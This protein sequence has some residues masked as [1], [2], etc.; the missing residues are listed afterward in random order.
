MG[1][2]G[3][4]EM[5]DTIPVEQITTFS[6][7]V[8]SDAGADDATARDA[9]SAMLHASLHGIDSHGFRLL[10]HY[11]MA[12]LGGRLNGAPVLSF[13]RTKAGTG[14]LDAGHAHGASHVLRGRARRHSGARAGIGAVGVRNS[15]HFG[16]AGA[17]AMALATQGLGGIVFGNSDSLVRLHD[18]ATRFHGTNPIAVG[19]PADGNPWLLDMATSSI[20]WNRV[21]LYGSL[22]ERLPEGI[23]SDESGMDVTDPRKAAMLA[24]LG[25]M[26]GFKGAALGGVAEIFSAVMT[27]M[28]ISPDLMS[29]DDPD[30]STRASSGPLLSRWTLGLCRAGPSFSAGMTHYLNLLRESPVRDGAVMAPGDRNGTK[31][32]AG[33]RTAFRSIRRPGVRSARLPAAP[34]SPCKPVTACRKKTTAWGGGFGSIKASF[35]QWSNLII[36]EHPE[37]ETHAHD[38]I[39]RFSTGNAFFQMGIQGAPSHDGVRRTKHVDARIAGDGEP[40]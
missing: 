8:L 39:A 37:P 36:F 26:F 5:G 16:A 29:M 19:F 14:V 31:R 23:A 22:G 6:A 27:G 3:S 32:H 24:P 40:C 35:S 2:R 1:K 4:G 17:Y 33:A 15:S 18:G 25:G 10:P 38:D 20:P 11:R 28:R 30:M 9:T 12:I 21:Q 13:V 34:A 7:A